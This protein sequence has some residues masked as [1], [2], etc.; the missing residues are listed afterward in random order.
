MG[1]AYHF[2]TMLFLFTG[3][4]QGTL[5]M[6]NRT[7]GNKQCQQHI[8]LRVGEVRSQA[9]HLVEPGISWGVSSEQVATLAGEPSAWLLCKIWLRSLAYR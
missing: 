2:N 5:L 9:G 3:Q 6:K 1:E 4:D 7:K 8:G